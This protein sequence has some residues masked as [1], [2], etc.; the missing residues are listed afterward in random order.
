MDLYISITHEPEKVVFG[1]PM[2]VCLSV[3]L[4][5][6]LS[7]CRSVCNSPYLG[8]RLTDLAEILDS[9]VLIKYEEGRSFSFLMT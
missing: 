2:S 1:I 4:S 5:V 3:G 7:V 9:G 8:N 6:C